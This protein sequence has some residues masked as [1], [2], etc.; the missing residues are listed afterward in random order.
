MNIKFSF[1]RSA[2]SAIESLCNQ[3]MKD[4]W[5]SNPEWLLAIPLLHFLRGDSKPFEEP[6]TGGSPKTLV[7]WGAQK[8]NITEFQRSD[9]Q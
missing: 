2:V 8:L 5:T 6:D 9:K 1:I 7:W 4:T 3:C